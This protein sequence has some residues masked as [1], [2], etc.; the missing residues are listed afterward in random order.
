MKTV[1]ILSPNK[2]KD[3]L[4]LTH[5]TEVHADGGIVHGIA[6]M[7]VDYTPGDIVRATIDLFVTPAPDQ[8]AAAAFT[9]QDPITGEKKTIRKIEFTD[10]SVVEL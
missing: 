8:T 2:D 6:G 10:G 9:M 5:G 4:T 1:R 7:S 3:G